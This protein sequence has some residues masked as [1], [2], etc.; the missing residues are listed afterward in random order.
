MI[1]DPGAAPA[2]PRGL[3][4]EFD[5]ALKADDLIGAIKIYRQVHGVGLKEARDEVL[6]MKKG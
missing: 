3:P 4:P 2:P 6:R 1:F 5:A